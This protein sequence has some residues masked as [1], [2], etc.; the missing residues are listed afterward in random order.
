MMKS[1]SSIPFTDIKDDQITDIKDDQITDIKDDSKL[2]EYYKN[3]KLLDLDD[4]NIS[5]GLD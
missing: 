5:D 1:H 2:K 3:A 4:C